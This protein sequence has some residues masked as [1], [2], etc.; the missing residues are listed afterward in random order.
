MGKRHKIIKAV[1]ENP[2]QFMYRNGEPYGAVVGAG[3]EVIPIRYRAPLS[4]HN[5]VASALKGTP[6]YERLLA[7]R[8]LAVRQEKTRRRRMYW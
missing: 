8:Q 2:S 7:V 3:G 6:E 4:N 1:K 5:L